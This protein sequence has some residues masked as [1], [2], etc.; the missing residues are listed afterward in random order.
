MK[1]FGGAPKMPAPA[2]LPPSEDPAAKAAQSAADEEER[3]KRA[4][5]GRASTILTGPLG[6]TGA[7]VGAAKQLLG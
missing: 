1:M 4:G 5:S 2:P 3:R 6:D 7:N